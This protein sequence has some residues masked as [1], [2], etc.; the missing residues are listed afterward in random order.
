M[1]LCAC[2]ARVSYVFQIAASGYTRGDVVSCRVGLK[3]ASMV[4]QGVWRCPVTAALCT[5]GC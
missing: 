2:P 3:V 4:R 1:F 5:A